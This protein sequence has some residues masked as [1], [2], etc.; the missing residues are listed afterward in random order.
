MNKLYKV[1]KSWIRAIIIALILALVFRAFMFQSYSVS[2]TTMEKSL[3]S[4]DFIIVNKLDFGAR[5]PITLISVPFFDNLFF[6]LIQLPYWRIPGINEIENNDIIVYNYPKINDLPIDKK[7]KRISRCVGIPGDTLRVYHKTVYI[8]NQE[9]DTIP[10]LQFVYRITTN[11]DAVNK[12]IL[13]KYNINE[14][15]IVANVGIYDFF[16]TKAIADSLLKEESIK[17]VRLLEDFFTKKSNDIFPGKLWNKDFFGSVI[18]PQKGTTVSLNSKNIQLY[19]RII[20][21]YEKNKLIIQDNKIYINSSE[22]DSYTFKMN[23]YFVMDDNRDNSK[24]SRNWGF[25]PEDHIIG[26]TWKIWFSIDKNKS[27]TR[28]NRIGSKT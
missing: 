21:T 13:E 17:Y 15:V 22:T 20:E 23:Y 11:G 19:K 28:W 1:F 2:G 3:Y 14:G 6:E 25:L 5:L 10:T 18:I 9:I 26:K 8:N 7:D 12:E 16:L 27:E 4:G 24:D